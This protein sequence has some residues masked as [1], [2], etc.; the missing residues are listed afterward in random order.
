[1]SQ[2]THGCHLCEPIVCVIFAFLPMSILIISMITFIEEQLKASNYALTV[3][4]SE[5]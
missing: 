5:I 1:M 4:T 2:A 3:L